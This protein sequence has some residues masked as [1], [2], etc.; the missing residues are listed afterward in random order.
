LDKTVSR[1]ATKLWDRLQTRTVNGGRPQW[2]DPKTV[3]NYLG[4]GIE[5]RISRQ[6]LKKWCEDNAEIITH[7]L[8]AKQT[9][10]ID[11]ID[12]DGHYERGNIRIIPKA[13]NSGRANLG[14]Q[15]RLTEQLNRLPPRHCKWC[16]KILTRNTF[17]TGTMEPSAKFKARITCGRS[18]RTKYHHAS[19]VVHPEYHAELRRLS[20]E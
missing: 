20:G 8:D 6:E 3:R 15:E 18:C 12:P 7:F 17:K 16:D 13:Q 14:R 9:P 1:F 4:K 5:L 11:R 10:S 2:N 19:G